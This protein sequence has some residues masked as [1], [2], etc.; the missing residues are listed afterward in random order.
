MTAF[1]SSANLSSVSAMHSSTFKTRI[2]LIDATKEGQRREEFARLYEPFIRYIVKVKC[3]SLR[4]READVDAVAQISLVRLL[5]HFTPAQQGRAPAPSAG[6]EPSS[7]WQVR[8]SPDVAV[9]NQPGHIT[10]Y[11]R[12]DGDQVHRFS[13]WL[14]MC[15]EGWIKDFVRQYREERIESI[16]PPAD[17][18]VKPTAP[19]LTVQPPQR[20]H[21]AELLEVVMA[22]MKLDGELDE[23]DLT[24]LSAV[25]DGYSFED[26]ARREA[27]PVPGESDTAYELRLKRKVGALRARKFALTTK[28]KAAFRELKALES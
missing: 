8:T 20:S 19:E 1:A 27:Q 11:E 3:Y 16:E 25:A 12:F 26:L 6:A 15:L 2:S 4:L 10:S 28:I 7:A 9:A 14:T 5:Y 17:D 23:A 18:M 21:D 24:L 22:R 13:A